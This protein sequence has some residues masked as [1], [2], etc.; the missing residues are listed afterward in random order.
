ME[1]K[2]GKR[3]WK[4]LIIIAAVLLIAFLVFYHF[5]LHDYSQPNI[6]EIP[7]TEDSWSTSGRKECYDRYY[8]VQEVPKTRAENEKMIFDF[9]EQ[10]NIVSESFEYET[11]GLALHFCV[12]SFDFPVYYE[13]PKTEWA[14]YA[15]VDYYKDNLFFIV[16]YDTEYSEPEFYYFEIYNEDVI[17]KFE[18]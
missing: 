9:I 5:R 8:M 7:E 15:Q 12:P 11:N 16:R 10:N 3:V 2:K 17:V 13:D 4:R 6:F 18:D 14:W 1:R